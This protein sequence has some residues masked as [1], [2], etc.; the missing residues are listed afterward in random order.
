M[1]PDVPADKLPIK[2]DT[3]HCRL[4]PAQQRKLEEGLESVSRLV[5]DFPVSELLV[6]IEHFP[7]TTRWRVKTSLVLTGETLV[8]L[9]EDDE[10]H[11]AFERCVANLVQDVHAYKDR[12]SQVSEVAK[13][14]KGTHQDL[15]PTVDP[16]PAA[17]DRAVNDG[18]YPAF[19]AATFGYEEPLRKRIGRWVER[20]PALSAQID[21]GLKIAD[22]VEEVFLNAFEQYARRPKDLRLG[23]WLDGLIDPALK[24]VAAHPDKELENINLARSA[25][26]AKQRTGPV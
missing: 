1:K 17:I 16:D 13:Q 5:R 8:S 26:A 3:K 7:R 9:N 23:Q 10:L 15:E 4:F 6:V 18:D 19:R 20:Y 25:W 11:P 14:L 22:L 21:K 2:W 12:M 24:E